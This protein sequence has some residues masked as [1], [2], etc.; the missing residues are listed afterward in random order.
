MDPVTAL[1]L[2]GN[3]VA[4]VQFSAALLKG[5]YKIYKSPT[6]QSEDLQDL[7]SIYAKLAEFSSKLGETDNNAI[8]DDPQNKVA[9]TSSLVQLAEICRKDCDELLEIIRKLSAKSTGRSKPWRCFTKAM[10]EVW[11]STE[12]TNLQKR[13]AHCEQAMVVVMLRTSR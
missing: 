13:V 5:T 9:Q 12:I 8:V 6:E 3:V 4:F 1:G 2:A 10:A 11:R 7:K